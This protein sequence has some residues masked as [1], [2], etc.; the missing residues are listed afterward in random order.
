MEEGAFPLSDSLAL[1]M[2]DGPAVP[3]EAVV[4]GLAAQGVR[5]RLRVV[6]RSV[7]ALALPLAQVPGLEIGLPPADEAEAFRL[8]ARE[9]LDRVDELDREASEAQRAAEDAARL[10]LAGDDGFLERLAD[11]RPA[12]AAA[13]AGAD[14]GEAQGFSCRGDSTPPETAVQEQVAPWWP[15]S[16]RAQAGRRSRRDVVRRRMGA[17]SRPVPALG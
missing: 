6:D 7:E 8:E 17:A 5:P 11:G 12:A 9:L 14:L 1:T 13:V 3:F 15:T 10:L 2:K 16:F 4:L